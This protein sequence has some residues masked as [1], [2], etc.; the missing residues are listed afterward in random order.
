MKR[1]S[2]GSFRFQH[3]RRDRATRCRMLISGNLSMAMTHSL[4]AIHDAI[5]VGVGTAL[6]DNPRLN[7]RSRACPIVLA[8]QLD[9]DFVKTDG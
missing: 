6:A 5:L 4:R 2:K 3:V 1:Y 8:I 9:A 7:V